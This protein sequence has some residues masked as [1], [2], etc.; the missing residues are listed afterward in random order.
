YLFKRGRLGVFGTKGFMDD[1]IISRANA[2]SPTGAVM[3]NII[4][5]R[6]LKIVDQVGISG[7]IGLFGNTYLVGNGGYLKSYGNADRFGG[8]LR[9][10]FPLNSKIALTAEGGVNE[11]LLARDN[12]GRAVFGV[13]FGNFMRPKDYLDSGKPV[14][15]EVPRVRYEVLTRTVRIGND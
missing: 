13:Q 1:G 12:S 5:E 6:Y 15:A 9:F 7:T 3:N 2:L 10:V 4:L 14:P 8:T 11:T